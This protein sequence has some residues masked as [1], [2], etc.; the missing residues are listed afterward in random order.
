M[1]E[2]LPV[3][4]VDGPEVG[5]VIYV[6]RMISH[7]PVWQERPPADWTWDGHTPWLPNGY[8]YGLDGHYERDIDR[9][10]DFLCG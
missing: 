2:G 6:D 7:V 9:E 3:I 1:S 4:L 10:A 8:W 5:R